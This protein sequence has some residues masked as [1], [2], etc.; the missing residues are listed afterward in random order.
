MRA[1]HFG[2]GNIGRGFIGAVLQDAG[3]FV[4]FADVN[5]ELIDKLRSSNSYSLI[6][7]GETE[8]RIHYE[9]F[10]VLNSTAHEA[11]LISAIGEAN[12]ITASVGTNILPFIAPVIASGISSR[13]SNLPLVIMACE[14]A[15]NA[16]DI[17][18]EKI[19]ESIEKLPKNISFANTAVDRIVPMQP[20]GSEPDVVAESFCEWVIDT[21]GLDGIDLKIPAAT[22][23]NDLQPFIER[24]IYT[25]NTAHLTIA[26]LGQR[27]G[28][29]TIAESLTDSIVRDVVAR[30][31]EE[32]SMVLVTKHGFDPNEHANYV[33]K[34]LLRLANPALD[35]QVERVG[36]Q[37]LRKLSRFERVIGPAALLTELDESPVALLEVVEAALEFT[38]SN[39]P[40]VE[41]LKAKLGSLS[42]AEFALEV[43]GISRDHR[44][45]D[46]LEQAIA[47]HQ[48]TRSHK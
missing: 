27:H 29:K 13:S 3:Y 20:F 23:V 25:V 32:T 22:M 36:R 35:D 42:P 44:L 11:A 39:D 21:S 6:E 24:K 19:L 15:I 45:A 26:Y 9:N 17:L 8:K 18:R 14:N 46:A 10:E 4:T 28:H 47:K 40:E 33:R 16:T 7:L 34:T 30:V 31:L 48:G 41:L 5:Q 1:V 2:A 37:P 43:C 38:S 12:V